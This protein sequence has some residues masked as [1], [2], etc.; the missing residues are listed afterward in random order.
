MSIKTV[1]AIIIALGIY[2]IIDGAGSILIYQSQPL[3]FDH[4][5]R[6]IRILIGIT[7]IIISFNVKRGYRGTTG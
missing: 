4:F 7:I 5:M 1:S 3:F 6:M 2:I